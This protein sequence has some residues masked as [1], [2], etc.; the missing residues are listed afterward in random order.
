MRRRPPRGVAVSSVVLTAHAKINIGWRVGR[1]RDDGFHPV[2]GLLQTL[3]LADQL[4]I[5]AVEG[6]AEPEFSLTVSGPYSKGLDGPDNLVLRSAALLADSGPSTSVEMHLEKQIPVAAGLGGGSADAAAA[7]VGLST[8]W[9]QRLI[10]SALTRTAAQLG[11]DVTPIL[12]G[13]L[14]AVQGRG[15][16][17]RA[18]TPSTGYAVVLGTS[19]SGLSAAEVYGRFDAVGPTESDSWT[20]NDL[21]NAVLDLMPGLSDSLE[22]M[23]TAGADVVFVSGSGPT[24]VGIVSDPNRAESVAAAARPHFADVL[25]TRPSPHGVRMTIGS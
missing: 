1:L 10:G 20:H 17:V 14:L 6:S 16:I 19:D 25:V 9:R 18:L 3:E 22:A 23:R 11:S 15:E 4:R 21:Q 13:G 5:T 2:S 24:V 12:I 8:I 7:L